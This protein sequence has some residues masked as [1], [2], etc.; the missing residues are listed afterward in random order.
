MTAPELAVVVLS[1]GAP[2]ELRLA[3]ESLLRQPEPLEIVV[4][5]SG[6]GDLAAVLPAAPGISTVTVEGLLWPGA[7]RNAG[8]RAT[9]APWVAFLASDL[10]AAPD[11]AAERLA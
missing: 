1:V 7:A 11:W 9:S 10:V 2:P 6:G 3:V 5:N 8:I 4:V